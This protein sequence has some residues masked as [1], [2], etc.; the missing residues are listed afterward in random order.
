MIRLPRWVHNLALGLLGTGFASAQD[1]RPA[2]SFV[3]PPLHPAVGAKAPA[4]GVLTSP[5]AATAARQP[6]V[7]LEAVPLPK[8][9]PAPAPVPAPMAV[10]LAPVAAGMPIYL[11]P[12]CGYDCA[13]ACGSCGCTCCWPTGRAWVDAEFLQWWPR[14][15]N[16]PPLVTGAAP[17]S[18]RA[19]AGALGAA[20]TTVLLGDEGL[21]SNLRSGFRVR[22][23]TWLNCDHTCG[24]EVGYTYLGNNGSSDT[25][26]SGGTPIVSRP[27]I[28]GQTG[29]QD[30]ELV[31][32]PNVLSG[33][34]NVQSG[35][36]FQ[37]LEG[38]AIWCLQCDPCGSWRVFAGY[39][40]LSLDEDLSITETL[41]NLDTTR[42]VPVGTSILVQDRFRS[43]NDFYG[44]RIGSQR[45]WYRG[46]LFA[47]AR[48][49]LSLGV[50]HRV[51]EVS[52]NTV[53]TT[54]GGAPRIQVGG[55][56]A[57]PTNIGR[58]VDN[59]FSFVPELGLRVG[60]QVSPHLR[61]SVGYDLLIW[62]NVIRA[63]SLIDPRVDTRQLSGNI[64]PGAVFPQPTRRDTD[65]W[66]QGVSFGLEATY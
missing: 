5:Y 26:G 14:G 10:A 39:R 64:I 56:L 9:A 57:Q 28:N 31:A 32:F 24:L 30:V 62:N 16:I 38:S 66:V 46:R 21:N 15:S 55:L 6:D 12:S 65:F 1:V 61:A 8:A 7:G 59:A 20:G 42:G 19:S 22:A 41:T 52:G 33:T 4:P 48:S 23:G 44:F 63:G 2:G 17:G 11:E 53:I 13:P 50:T 49:A 58:V 36:N 40:G 3:M 60:V 35:L 25:F 54:P 34:V 27:F 37:G 43:Q 45:E 18:P 29:L 51:T 47:S